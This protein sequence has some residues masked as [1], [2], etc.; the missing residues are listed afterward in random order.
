[1]PLSAQSLTAKVDV[2]VPRRIVSYTSDI[3]ALRK[4]HEICLVNLAR[5]KDSF[6]FW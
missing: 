3:Q 4:E 6:A 2:V 5:G 1:M